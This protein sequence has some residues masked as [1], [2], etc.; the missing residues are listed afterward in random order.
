[1]SDRI[2][3]KVAKGLDRVR[4]KLGPAG[5]LTLLN[6]SGKSPGGV[7]SYTVV[8]K[9]SSG[10]AP[11]S[12]RGTDGAS[13]VKLEVADIDGQ[14]RDL[15]DGAGDTDRTTHFAFGGRVYRVEPEQT[16]R[17]VSEPYVWELRGYETADMYE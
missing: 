7:N 12:K 15:V 13:Y 4:G 3:A 14:L 17:P 16:L 9:S 5:D 6:L 10:W 8:G 2:T 1:M 11:E